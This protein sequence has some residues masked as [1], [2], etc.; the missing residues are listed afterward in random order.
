MA[1][2]QKAAQAGTLESGDIMIQVS[3]GEAGKGL[4]VELESIV[5]IQYGEAI[6]QTL[7]AVAQEQ[8]VADVQVKA[9][10]RG[11]L[12]CTIRARFLTA[13]SRAGVSLKGEM[14]SCN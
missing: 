10:D 7:Q 6:R 5:M 11:A 4:S 2:V 13:L 9:V 8:G 3:P 1:S 12:D 14:A